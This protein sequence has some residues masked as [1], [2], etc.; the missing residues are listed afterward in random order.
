M[1]DPSNRHTSVEHAVTEQA[2]QMAAGP[3]LF[4]AEV[5][6]V[7]HSRAAA[8]YHSPRKAQR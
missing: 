7:S 2:L 8:F 4:L 1:I 3:A 6:R 5:I